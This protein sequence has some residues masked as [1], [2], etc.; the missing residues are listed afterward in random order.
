[1]HGHHVIPAK[2]DDKDL[3]VGLRGGRCWGLLGEE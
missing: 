3:Y 1:M 2:L